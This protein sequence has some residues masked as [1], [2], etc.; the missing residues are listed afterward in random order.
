MSRE[1]TVIKPFTAKFVSERLVLYKKMSYPGL[2]DFCWSDIIVENFID[3]NARLNGKYLQLYN[4]YGVWQNDT[5]CEEFIILMTP[6]VRMFRDKRLRQILKA[7]K[8]E[9]ECTCD[10]SDSSTECK[11]CESMDRTGSVLDRILTNLEASSPIQKKE[12]KELVQAIKKQLEPEYND[13]LK[14]EQEEKY[15]EIQRKRKKSIE[16]IQMPDRP[17]LRIPKGIRLDVWNQW[18]GKEKGIAPCPCC[19]QREMQQGDGST[20]N[21]SHVI[22]DSKGG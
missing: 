5:G 13:R 14:R 15:L 18:I 21:A 7:V 20:W 4:E 1:C 8:V 16:K 12:W 10:E 17:G 3:R 22:A 9:G 2:S 19:N 6:I 11:V